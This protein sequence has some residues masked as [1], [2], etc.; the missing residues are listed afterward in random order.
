MTLK[1]SQSGY[2]A[3]Q[4]LV[5]GWGREYCTKNECFPLG[6]PHSLDFEVET[7]ELCSNEDYF[8]TAFFLSMEQ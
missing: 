7:D 6:S 3:N 1:D 5:E 2:A 4:R 8:W